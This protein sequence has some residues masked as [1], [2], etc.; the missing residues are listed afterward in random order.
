MAAGGLMGLFSKFLR[1]G[2]AAEKPAKPDRDDVPDDD[3]IVL[4]GGTQGEPKDPL[5]KRGADKRRHPRVVQTTLG[6]AYGKPRY[7]VYGGR[8]CYEDPSDESATLGIEEAKDRA[9]MP[10]P[11][12]EGKV[13]LPRYLKNRGDK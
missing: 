7:W 12:L 3:E 13:E 5:E 6:G 10:R 11:D 1:P 8:E 9:A 2:T 4:G